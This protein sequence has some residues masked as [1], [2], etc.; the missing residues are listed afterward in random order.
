MATLDNRTRHSH[1]TLDGEV[2]DND[3][4]F[5]NGCRFPGDPNGPPTEIYN[6]RCTLVSAIDGID[7]SSGKRR[8][9]NLETGKNEVIDHGRGRQRV[10]HACQEEKRKEN[11]GNTAQFVRGLHRIFCPN[12]SVQKT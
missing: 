5:S 12:P 11:T 2:V 7:T 4:K 10:D 9:R 8:A 1:A 3:K 6:C